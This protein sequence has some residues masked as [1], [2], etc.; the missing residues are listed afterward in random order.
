MDKPALGKGGRGTQALDLPRL[1]F[2]GAE[3]TGVRIHTLGK[4]YKCSKCGRGFS[5]HSDLITHQRIHTGEKPYKCG[6]CRTG[7]MQSAGLI[8][9]QRIHTGEKLRKLVSVERVSPTARTSGHTGECTL[10][11]NPTSAPSMGK[12]SVRVP[13]SPAI[14]GEKPYECLER[15]KRFS[16]RSNVITHRR[17]RTGERPYKCGECGESFSQ[18]SNLIIHQRIHT[19]EKPYGCAECGSRFNNSS[20]ISAGRRAHAG[21]RL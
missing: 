20:R 16:D 18:S 6:E 8:M 3:T 11:K 1:W 13:L 15:G 7:F 2:C 19:G 17:I 4:P 10:A 14:R 21:E 9:H 12:R 5:D